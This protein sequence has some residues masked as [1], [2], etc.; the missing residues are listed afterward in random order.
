MRRLAQIWGPAAWTG[1]DIFTH[2]WLEMNHYW[3]NFGQY[4][5]V[6]SL[7]RQPSCQLC[8]HDSYELYVCCRSKQAHKPYSLIIQT[9]GILQQTHF[10]QFWGEMVKIGQP[11]SIIHF[12]GPCHVNHIFSESI[13]HW[14]PLP[15]C[16]NP[17][18]PSTNQY[19]LQLT[20]YH[21]VSTIIALYWSSTTKYQQVSPHT[22]LVPSYINQYRHLLTQ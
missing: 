13:S 10:F 9:T 12:Q 16:S 11:C 7:N 4:L 2:S 1:L 6:V 18:P 8:I 19:R 21:H 14:Q 5:S 3:V 15:P 17:V 22:D 20:Q